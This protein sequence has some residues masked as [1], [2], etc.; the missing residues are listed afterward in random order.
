MTAPD[1]PP[2]VSVKLVKGGEKPHWSHHE[3]S[4]SSAGLRA[5]S[6]SS[7]SATCV[8]SGS[9]R[10]EGAVRRTFVP[11]ERFYPRGPLATDNLIVVRADLNDPGFAEQMPLVLSEITRHA[12]TT[13]SSCPESMKWLREDQQ[14]EQTSTAVGIYLPI[15]FTAALGRAGAASRRPRG[16]TTP[17]G[18]RSSVRDRL[19]QRAR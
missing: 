13:R 6:S 15:T 10:H 17:A 14:P 7:S 9:R 2:G 11:G 4:S 19:G 16:T 1:P 18:R 3:R 12:A 8:W 5:R